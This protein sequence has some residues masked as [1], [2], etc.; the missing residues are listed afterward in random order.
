MDVNWWSDN[1]LSWYGN[2]DAIISL[3]AERFQ[4]CAND[5]GLDFWEHPEYLQLVTNKMLIPTLDIVAIAGR[6]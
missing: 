2:F 6:T 3:G 1:I 4:I 5:G